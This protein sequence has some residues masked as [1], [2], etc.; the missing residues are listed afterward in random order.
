MVLTLPR[1]LAQQAQQ[2]Q[3]ATNK[4]A[5]C[6]PYHLGTLLAIFFI[7]ISTLVR[8]TNQLIRVDTLASPP[9]R[10]RQRPISPYRLATSN[11]SFLFWVIRQ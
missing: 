3:P 1:H 10:R 9:S 11:Q 6:V 8:S 2:V 4:Q 7:T 5:T